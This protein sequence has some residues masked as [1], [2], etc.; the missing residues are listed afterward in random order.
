MNDAGGANVC[1]SGA[2]LS[3]Q[4]ANV[5]LLFATSLL[6]SNPLIHNHCADIFSSDV[7]PHR[8]PR[9][10]DPRPGHEQSRQRPVVDATLATAQ[11]P[12]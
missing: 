12:A 6:K 1:P 11:V 9:V 8:L 7:R 2:S 10:R 5:Y 3:R 4:G